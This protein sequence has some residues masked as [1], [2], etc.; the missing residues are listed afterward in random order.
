MKKFLIIGVLFAVFPFV[1]YAQTT[2]TTIVPASSTVTTVSPGL[3]PGDFFYFLDNWGEAIRTFFTFNIEAKARLDLEYARER[4][5]EIKQV[6]S[7]PRRKLE[8]IV[9]AQA[10]FDQHIADAAAIVKD[11]KAAGTDVSE[12]AKELDDELD[13]SHN[14]IKDALITHE[15]LTSTGE[16]ELR[17]KIEALPAGDP[18]IEG[19][20]N[21]LEQITKEKEGAQNESS[22]LENKV[23]DQQA[24]FEDAM[25]PKI[26]AEKH[27]E[28][29]M[30]LREWMGKQEGGLPG[31]FSSSTDQL[32]KQAEEALKQGDFETAKNLSEEAKHNAEKSRE[33]LQDG[34]RPTPM[35]GSDRD[36]H[37]CIPS[38]GYSW[39]E[40]K[41]ACTRPWED[42]Q[43]A[44]NGRGTDSSGG[45]TEGSN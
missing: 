27:L 12:L 4:A 19:L 6:L 42:N 25:G 39:N 3:L 44:D 13:F 7:D 14:D 30:R 21:A 10:N 29:V 22:D 11:E 20:T 40:S 28:Q 5:A 35:P 38:A 34:E 16:V 36:S 9:G 37:G 1:T 8:D 43:G 17:A 24:V 32:L 33:D 23:L 26:S 18:Q 31:S 2:G 41:N 15:N 45:S